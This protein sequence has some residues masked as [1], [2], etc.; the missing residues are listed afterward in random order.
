MPKNNIE[1]TSIIRYSQSGLTEDLDNLAVEE[2][3]EIRIN[4][5]PVSITMRTP[6]HD[7]ELSIGFLLTEGIIKHSKDIGLISYCKSVPEEAQQNV[8]NIY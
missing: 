8:L 3:L 7:E 2:P 6:G 1:R 5:N 4:G